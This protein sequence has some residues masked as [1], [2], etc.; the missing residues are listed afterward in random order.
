[1]YRLLLRAYPAEFRAAYGR[2]MVL[3]FGDRRREPGTRVV[4]FWAAM[5]WDVARS[6]PALRLEVW[7]ARRNAQRRDP[8]IHT[9]EGTMR[10][11]AILAVVIG[12]FEL[13]NAL[14]EGWAGGTESPSGAWLVAVALGMIAVVLLV[15]TGI[16]LLRRASGAPTWARGA[17]VA[18]LALFVVTGLVH[19]WMS[20]ISRV[21]GVGVPAALLIALFVTR[22]RG[23][24]VRRPKRPM[25]SLWSWPRARMRSTGIASVA[26]RR[27]GAAR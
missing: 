26:A 8:T 10:P 11:M 5:V 17:A 12:G 6:A 22:G 23:P 20:V 13:V 19:P 21:L 7:R 2:D 16:A 25:L 3:L 15:A 18:S 24:S 4:P 1:V 27:S 9:Q 14:V